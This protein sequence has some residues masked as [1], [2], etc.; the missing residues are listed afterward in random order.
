VA[1][2]ETPPRAQGWARRWRPPRA[3]VA[4]AAGLA[5]VS[6]LFGPAY[7]LWDPTYPDDTLVT[8]V[9]VVVALTAPVAWRRVHPGAALAVVTAGYVGGV[10]APFLGFGWVSGDGLLALIVVAFTAIVEG[11]PRLRV[12][13]V[14][15]LYSWGAIQFAPLPGLDP[16][17]DIPSVLFTVVVVALVVAAADAVR[18][19][20]MLAA[21]NAER[22]DQAERLRVLDARAAIRDERVRIGRDLHDVVA[23]RLSAVTM[24][25]T[26]ARHVQGRPDVATERQVLDEVGREVETALAEL[27]SVVGVLRASEDGDG[28]G[29]AVPSLADVPALAEDLRRAGAEVVVTERG[30]RHPLPRTVD[31]AAYR[32]LQEALVNVTRHADPPRATV[33]I[34]HG[35]DRLLLRVD[36]DGAA[37]AGPEAAAP[38]GPPGY[39]LTGMRERAALC[40]GTAAAGPR[41]GG[42]W[43]V[44]AC[45]PTRDRGAP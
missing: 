25:L 43:T 21:A 23:N 6:V 9:V 29:T 38:A 17:I 20:G 32:I 30:P 2:R 44:T 41:P 7:S 16:V 35:D 8:D 33:L 42:G 24:R 27:R 12:A 3:D 14:V 10:V 31:V 22:A 13:A 39:G 19:R 18:N 40:G 26:A 5:V 15:V 45:L 34:E 28:A 11:T 36:D 1:E 4:L 37:P